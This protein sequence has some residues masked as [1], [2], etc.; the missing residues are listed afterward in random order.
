MEISIVEERIKEKLILN[1][2]KIIENHELPGLAVGIVKGNKIL[3]AKGFGVC[4]LESQEPITP[5]TN[6][7]LCSISKTFVATSIM[8]LRE[9]GRIELTDP[10]VKHLPYFTVDDPSSNKITIKQMLYHVSRM[11][12]LDED[13]YG[14]ENPEFDEKAL[15]NYVKSL[16]NLKLLSHS[17][18]TFSYSNIAYEILGDLISKVS[19]ISF[20]EYVQK[21]IFEPLEMEQSTFILK[22]SPPKN[23][24]LPHVHLPHT[25]VPDQQ[26][27]YNR[28]HAPSSTLHSNVYDM[29]K[30]IQMNLNRGTYNEKQI[31]KSSSF[32]NLWNNDFN[33]NT[34]KSHSAHIGL[35]W[36][37]GNFKGH[38]CVG[39]SGSDRGFQSHLILFPQDSLG[40]IVMINAYPSPEWI[41]TSTII[42]I[43]YD[44][45]LDS[46]ALK[47]PITYPMG[48]VLMKSGIDAT[49]ELF[50]QLKNSEEKN[51]YS[52]PQQFSF[53]A[54]V[55]KNIL[56]MQTEAKKI[57]DLA[58][59]EFPNSIEV[60]QM[61]DNLE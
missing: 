25:W 59:Q 50:S 46:E 48:K 28:A 31:L 61:R 49:L 41:I 57:L 51:Y 10:I 60:K 36:F 40:I 54:F 58:I 53:L 8:Q 27:P 16:K 45:I 9:S 11:P 37:S 15:E 23:E 34:K 19:G 52:D 22:S 21:N 26:Y 18:P 32:D 29:C 2:N 42:D 33:T 30:F 35:S 14:W 1:I 38:P 4:H 5:N 20:E 55:L 43:L 7:H 17:E 13:G 44:E 12:D 56:N 47:I 3:F 24:A 39:H 6:F